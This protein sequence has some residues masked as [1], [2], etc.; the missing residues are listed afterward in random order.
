MP[1]RESIF[2]K[3]NYF[4]IFSRGNEKRDIFNS[5]NDYERFLAKLT[6]YQ[7]IH[8][9]S[10][11]CYCLMPNHFHLLL[12]QDTGESA[13]RFM[14]RLMVSYAMYFNKHYHRVG[15]LFQSRFKARHIKDDAYILQLSRYIHQN[16]LEIISRELDLESYPW[17]SYAEYINLNKRAI[18]EKEII[19]HHFNTNQPQYE[20]KKFVEETI[21]NPPPSTIKDLILE[22]H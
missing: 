9:V 21:L 22:L 11:I 19:L 14:H 15:H 6:E 16:P 8:R 17:S 3:G 1:Y 10:I 13:S 7:V 20:Y 2:Y 5:V 4:H 18:C 12:R